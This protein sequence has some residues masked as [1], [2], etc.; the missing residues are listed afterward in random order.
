MPIRYIGREPFFKGK[1]LYELCR[2][3]RDL[4]V[5]RI[6]YQKSV[7]LKWPA[8]KSYYRLTKVIP[9]MSCKVGLLHF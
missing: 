9:K 4:G 6:V 1:P 8:Q 7:E 2:Q 5:G 3:L